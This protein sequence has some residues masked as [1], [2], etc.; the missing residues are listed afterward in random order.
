MT[1]RRWLAALGAALGLAFTAPAALA[2]S[3]PTKPVKIIAPVQP[4]GGVDLVGRTVAE[5]LGKSMGGSFIVENVS[6]G[7][8]VIASQTVAR[9]A[10]DGYTLMVGYVATHGTNPAVRKVPY[11]PVKDFTAI[12]MVGGTPNVLVVNPTVPAKTLKEFIAY[13]KGN[14]GKL[15]YGSSGQGSLTHLAMEQLKAAAGFD[16]AHA[17]YRGIGPAI[18]DILGG[19]TQMMLPGLAAALPHVKA[20]KMKPIAVTGLKR[21]PLLPD[22][23]TL[24]EQGFKGFDGV[25]WYGIVGP[26]RM[27]A[28][29]TKKLNE[30]VNKALASPQLRE[31]LA[32]EALEP[33]PMSPDQFAKFIQ[34]DIARWSKL[35]K[36]RNIHLED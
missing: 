34:A 17:A 5:Q 21:H 8:G 18:T 20:G 33:M 28:E 4:G 32:G 13:A 25:Q 26:A 35:A 14:P 6:G 15:S 9:A 2:Q 16:A 11:D 7:G 22:V 23:P 12:A 30:E 29:L 27:P 3:Y 19:Q 24:E 1:H 31:R 10:P 36:D